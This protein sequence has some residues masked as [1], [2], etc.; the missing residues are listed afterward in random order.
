[1]GT[2]PTM[3]T[4]FSRYL[5]ACAGVWLLGGCPGDDSGQ[6]GTETANNDTGTSMGSADS[7]SGTE[8]GAACM[9]SDMEVPALDLSACVADANDYQPTVNDSADDAWPACDNDGGG[10]SPFE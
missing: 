8:T 6:E 10:Y 3:Q 2:V 4:R 1:M 9:P 5:M 7:G